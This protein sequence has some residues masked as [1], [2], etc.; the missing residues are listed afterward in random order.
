[1]P[2]EALVNVARKSLMSQ[3]SNPYEA[4]SV[5]K[6]SRR[7]KQPI[8]EAVTGASPEES[9]ALPK[10]NVQTDADL[11]QGQNPKIEKM[12]ADQGRAQRF[13]EI[14]TVGPQCSFS[15]RERLCQPV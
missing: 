5:P 3:K 4:Y 11:L 15:S 1:M 8:E 2:E 10:A 12:I 14:T 13:A 9:N 7:L 6:I